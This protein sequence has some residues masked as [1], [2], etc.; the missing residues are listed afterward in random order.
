MPELTDI[1]VA[2][3]HTTEADRRGFLTVRRLSLRHRYDDG[4]ASESYPYDIVDRP[5]SDATA[6]ILWAREAAGGPIRVAIRHNVRPPITL[7]RALTLPRA[8][9][10][11]PP[12][13]LLAE[14][15]AGSLEP[16]DRGSAG[17]FTRA[18]AEAHEEAGARVDPGEGVELGAGFYPAPGTLSEKVYLVAFEVPWATTESAPPLPGDGSVCERDARLEWMDLHDALAACARG[19]FEDGK[20]EIALRRLASHLGYLP[21]LRCSIDAL[22]PEWVA[23]YRPIT[24]PAVRSES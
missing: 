21:E 11:A 9:E 19:V 22:P 5:G 7:R 24:D 20:T 17:V 2:D 3:D 8:A 6:A 23:R 14:V 15:C 13:L 1:E 18:A 12:P 10:E 16:G 4:S